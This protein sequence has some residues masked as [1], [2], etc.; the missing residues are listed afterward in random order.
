[1]ID[2]RSFRTSIVISCKYEMP[3]IPNVE[4]YDNRAN[5]IRSMFSIAEH[6]PSQ[7]VRVQA[8]GNLADMF[9]AED[10]QAGATPR[11]AE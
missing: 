9:L 6:D 1:M 7:M 8:L 10:R 4:I 5:Y 3:Y 2:P 11:A